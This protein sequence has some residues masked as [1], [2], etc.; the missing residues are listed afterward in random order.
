MKAKSPAIR[1]ALFRI[2]VAIALRLFLFPTQALAH[3]EV[4]VGSIAFSTSAPSV[5]GLVS[6]A[7]PGF[8][9]TITH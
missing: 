2:V 3:E 1:A 8:E 5:I 7:N 6:I 4:M 9:R